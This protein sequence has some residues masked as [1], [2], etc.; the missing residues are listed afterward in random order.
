MVNNMVRRLKP[1]EKSD[2][3]IIQQ[4]LGRKLDHE[5]KLVNDFGSNHINDTPASS[6]REKAED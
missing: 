1:E 3:I 2:L 5:E 6:F 4:L